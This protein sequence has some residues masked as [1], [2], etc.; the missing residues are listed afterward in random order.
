[1]QLKK[2]I[3][4]LLFCFQISIAPQLQAQCIT[5]FPYHETFETSNG[6]W[7]S[8]GTAND[9]AWGSPTK[10][11]ISSAGQGLKCWIVGGL[12]IS[13]Y[14]NAERSYVQ[15]PCF[16][17]TNLA[18]PYIQFLIF[19]ESE[20]KYDGGNLQY[21]INSGTTWINVGAYND[22]VDCYNANWYNYTPITA[23]S[24]LATIKD[25]WCGNIQATSGSCQGGS[26]SG[27]WVVAKHCLSNLAGQANVIFRFTF[28][29]GTSCN[30][31]DGIA[32]DDVFIENAPRNNA[33]FGFNCTTTN[34]FSF[35]DSSTNCAT[36]WQWNFGDVASGAANSSTLQSP[37]HLFSSAGIYNVQLISTNACSGNDTV[38]KQ[39]SV[40]GLSIDSVNISCPNGN[41]GSANA[42]VVGANTTLNYLWNTTPTQNTDTAKNLAAGNY[43][44][45]V[46]QASTCA[47]SAT[48]HL[49]QPNNFVH[50]FVITPSI[51][52]TANGS[53]TVTENGGTPN[54]SYQWQ[55]S[56]STANV[57]TAILSGNYTVTITDQN[58]CV[59]TM[60]LFVPS[61]GGN[62]VLS[63]INHK[64]V[65]CFGGN[66]G[67]AT[68]QITGGTPAFQYNWSPS[69][70]TTS[71]A[72]NLTQGNY[73]VTVTDANNCSAQISTTISQPTKM[74]L[75]H[76]FQNTTC[77]QNN[78]SATLNVSGATQ[79]YNYVWSPS[80]S[81][82]NQAANL[83]S[84]N[85]FVQIAD[86]HLCVLH[87]T[88]LIKK[89]IALQ[90]STSTTADTCNKFKGTASA[91]II[92]GTAPFQYLW[93]PTGSNNS[94]ISNLSFGKNYLVIVGD[95]NQC[96][97]TASVDIAS[98][99][100]F[101]INLGNDTFICQGYDEINLSPG[102]FVNYLWQDG[103]TK[104]SFLVNDVGEYFVAVKNN[105]GCEASDTIHILSHCEGNFVVPNAFTPNGDG[106]DDEFGGITNYPDELV[107]YRLTIYNRWGEVVFENNNYYQRWDGKINGESQSVG[108]F[109]YLLQYSFDKNVANKMLKGDVTLLR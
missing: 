97:D 39:I 74:L 10:P 20:H 79:P 68:V 82:T 98:F 28:G 31:F 42:V 90:I 84:G 47:I 6:G 56:V 108:V 4:F 36:T 96:K 87:D 45:T 14:N 106:L 80:V 59:D 44:V 9:W 17:F 103:S 102:N 29:A 107:Y 67:T 71:T 23:L 109:V 93:Q 61:T 58:N 101:Q 92:S 60:H 73:A 48:V 76:Q 12:S 65:S 27:A 25:G 83:L 32:F 30:A 11:T 50:S 57:A 81:T 16:D 70:G 51:C 85:Y 22:P 19:W 2:K 13:S 35:T 3:F 55:P 75:S 38:L 53:A 15:S 40:L 52:G 77:G 24:T 34:N 99:G 104:N 64:N 94:T 37:T 105:V 1:M 86:S 43:S 78:G 89:S 66:D 33:N 5:A 8:G 7:T 72:N 95:S 41:N 26:G 49:K 62:M 18:H 100:E 63:I 69:G 54:Y 21:S 46:S 91:Q 88:F